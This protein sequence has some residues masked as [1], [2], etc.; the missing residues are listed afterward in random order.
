[1]QEGVLSE[2]AVV[3]V[4]TGDS[5]LLKGVS[6]PFLVDVQSHNVDLLS[7]EKIPGGTWTAD[8]STWHINTSKQDNGTNGQASLVLDENHTG[9]I[10]LT[11]TVKVDGVEQSETIYAKAV[12]PATSLDQPRAM[13]RDGQ[14]NNNREFTLLE[15]GRIS[16]NVQHPETTDKPSLAFINW[17]PN[18]IQIGEVQWDGGIAWANIDT[19]G[20]GTAKVTASIY[21]EYEA[22][23]ITYDFDIKVK[24]AIP[25]KIHLE[26]S[27][28]ELY[29]NDP[30]SV[31][32]NL[33]IDEPKGAAEYAIESVTWENTGNQSAYSISEQTKES[34]KVSVNERNQTRGT[35]KVVVK[36]PA[37]N[38]IEASATVKVMEKPLIF[39]LQP[40]NGEQVS[41]KANEWADF[42]SLVG[43]YGLESWKSMSGKTQIYVFDDGNVYALKKYN[44]SYGQTE[45]YYTGSISDFINNTHNWQDYLVPVNTSSPKQLGDD[46]ITVGDIVTFT[47]S[48]NI[49]HYYVVTE[50]VNEVLTQENIGK[51]AGEVQVAG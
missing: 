30:K 51:Y 43:A 27:E 34:C 38:S 39:E 17:N 10:L 22:K 49:V 35:L 3:Y 24:P 48:S 7:F 29:L 19:I 4:G 25:T 20:V 18:I 1:M 40:E 46:G 5:K 11:Y 44:T 15:E 26:P 45:V 36:G 8:P 2:N 21:C 13:Y 14:V 50:T 31:D 42:Q 33:V 16:I 32:V 28:V 6:S 47:D 41:L 9:N 37:G 23:F 12:Q